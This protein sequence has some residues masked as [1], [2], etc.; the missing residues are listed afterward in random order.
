M[1]NLFLIHNRNLSTPDLGFSGV[2][3]VMRQVVMEQAGRLGIPLAVKMLK[4]RDLLSA[5]G[6]FLTNSLI[7]IWPVREVNAKKYDPEA[8][9]P[10]LVDAVMCRGFRF[11]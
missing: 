9:S 1:S 6:L 4:M 8:V 10:S 3:G 11:E 7:G 5:N 2:A